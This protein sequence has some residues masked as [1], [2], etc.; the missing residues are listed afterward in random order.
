MNGT[1]M[2]W[3]CPPDTWQTTEG[4]LHMRTLPKTDFWRRT[5]YGFS[6]DD[7]HLWFSRQPGDFVAEVNVAAQPNAKYDQAGLMIR[8]HPDCWLKTS[9][10]YQPGLAS[11]LGAVVTN[12]GYSDWSY[13]PVEMFPQ[14]IRFRVE[15]HGSDYV[16]AARIGDQALQTHRVAHL[17]DDDGRSAVQ[18][19]VYACSP[20]GAGCD[21]IFSDL[22]IAAS[23]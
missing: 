10:E 3:H 19:G 9:C 18:V 21:V 5:H 6:R 16:I 17:A 23:A 13:Q 15:R 11:Q 7:G 12:G 14:S 8:L 4:G 2:E 20:D 22:S 1:V